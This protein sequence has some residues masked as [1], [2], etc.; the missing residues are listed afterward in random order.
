MVP[1]LIVC[2]DHLD[3]RA[4]DGLRIQ[5]LAS[6]IPQVWIPPHPPQ[7]ASRS[8][9]TAEGYFSENGTQYMNFGDSSIMVGQGGD[10]VMSS[11]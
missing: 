4:V 9:I 6:P 7:L 3:P 2:R 11:H 5:Y 10:I 1:Q 8:S